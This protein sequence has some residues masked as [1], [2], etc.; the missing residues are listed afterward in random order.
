[1]FLFC[2]SFSGMQILQIGRPKQMVRDWSCHL[3]E[4][5]T[6]LQSRLRD[7]G[8]KYTS[9]E[10]TSFEDLWEC[11]TAAVVTVPKVYC[12]ADALDEMEAGHDW[13]LPKLIELG[14]RHPSTAKV[15]VT[16]RQS[17]HI[18]RIFKEPLVIP[19]SL[20]RHLIDCDIATYVSHQLS[21]QPASAFSSE[22]CQLIKSTVQGKAD[23]LFLYAR[24]MMDE[25][26]QNVENKDL[27]PLLRDLP[28]G[29]DRM[30][31]SLLTQHSLRSGVTHEVQV[32]I[33]QW[34]THASRPLR[35]LELAELVRSVPTESSLGDIQEIKNVIRSACGPLLTILPDETLQ[36]IHHSFT[37]FLV[38][39]TS[40]LPNE[41]AD[42]PLF[43]S[44][45]IHATMATTCLEYLSTCSSSSQ[46]NKVSQGKTLL[47]SD[48]TSSGCDRLFLENPLLQYVAN[49]WMIH[50]SRLNGCGADLTDSLDSFLDVSKDGFPY[51]QGIWHCSIQKR[52][53]NILKPLHVL[54]YFGLG[55]YVEVLCRRGFNLDAEDS[56]GRTPLS[57]ACERGHL[58]LVCLLLDNEASA[59][60][61]STRG[62]AP[63]HY[64]CKSELPAVVRRLLEA[65]VDPL[66]ETPGPEGRSE[67][68]R[69]R[70]GRLEN[71]ERE[72]NRRLFGV[73]ALE[74]ACTRGY[75]ECA[76][77]M[78]DFLQDKH[79]KPGALHCA[80]HE[81]RT[82]IVDLLLRRGNANPD[83]EDEFGHTPLCLA[84]KRGSPLIVGALLLAGAS[85][86]KYSSCV[87]R[88]NGSGRGASKA[89]KVKVSP[90]HAWASYGGYHRSSIEEM[91]ATGLKLIG[92]GC[93]V[94]SRD[95]E[96]RTPLFSWSKLSESSASVI[97][98]VLLEH[99]AP[100]KA[101]DNMGNTL[102]HSLQISHSELLLQT[103]IEA[104]ADINQARFIDGRTPMLCAV[105]RTRYSRS[106]DWCHYVRKF[107]LDPNAQDLE[108]KTVLHH[109]LRCDTWTVPEVE[110]WLRAGAD[111]ARQDT[112]GR[113]CLFDF[114]A[115]FYTQD[116]KISREA[117]LFSML[118]SAGLDMESR[119]HQGRNLALNAS[120]DNRLDYLMRLKAYGINVTA[121]DSQGR[122]A[123]HLLA[124]GG[125]SCTKTDANGHQ[126][127]L[128]CLNFL[129]DEGVDPN[130][131]DHLGNTMLHYCISNTGPFLKTSSFLI[132]TSLEVGADPLIRNYQGRSLLHIAA[133]LPL[134]E[135]SGYSLRDGENRLEL[136][137]PPNMNIDV[138][139]RDR[140]GVT[141]L[142]LAATR[143]AFRVARLLSSGSNVAAID[144][145]RRSALHY[146]ARARNSN[147]LGLLLATLKEQGAQSLIDQPDCNGRTPLHDAVRSGILESIQLLLDASSNPNVR[148]VKGRGCLHIASEI[149]EEH[150]LSALYDSLQRYVPVAKTNWNS[151][152]ELPEYQ[153]HPSGIDYDDP[154]ILCPNVRRTEDQDS[155]DLTDM[156]SVGRVLDV[157]RVLLHA[158]TD[159]S[160]TDND[161]KSAYNMAVENSCKDAACAILSNS[162][163]QYLIQGLAQERSES[164]LKYKLKRQSWN[165]DPA[166]RSRVIRSLVTNPADATSYLIPAISDGNESTINILLELG[167]DPLKA[168]RGELTA[169]H[170]SARCGMTSIMKLLVNKVQ[171]R[172]RLPS[173]LLHEAA[174][175]D[176]P[177]L[178]MI[179]LLV[180]FGIDINALRTAHGNKLHHQKD[181]YKVT[182]AHILAVSEHWWQP[183]ALDY[184]LEARAD[185]EVTTSAGKTALQVAIRGGFGRHIR[186]GFWR[187]AAMKTLLKHGAKVNYVDSEGETPLIEA[188]KQDATTIHTLISHGADIAFGPTSPITHAVSY[189][190][191]VEATA[192]L[193]V[194][195]FG[196]LYYPLWHLLTLKTSI[197]GWCGPEHS[198]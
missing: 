23:G 24:L 138:D 175:R 148:D 40:N 77:T 110:G 50:T 37:E 106:R 52:D 101:Q 145:S 189:P 46:Q 89:G 32:L 43:V 191:N 93:D 124:L 18:E 125:V 84:A 186:G 5:S 62:I 174:R 36:V 3:L 69:G 53:E 70:V 13:F 44:D 139:S 178:E 179:K 196:A 91:R 134:P 122:T 57:Y 72:C 129:K 188:A 73:N 34:I 90:L 59:S 107:G 165:Q 81:S 133:G 173:T 158:G 4:H 163:E 192:A 76:Q 157:V 135:D 12:V 6:L 29:V 31:T 15:M 113:H 198:F 92:A 115:C 80:V 149:Q 22:Q 1:M 180:N 21:K 181:D 126:R 16:S 2:S 117:R 54:A 160:I 47:L 104:G 190:Y 19:I 65:G 119:D 8:E 130:E 30:Y 136:L 88:R 114:Y 97:I 48:I 66:L 67:G 42:Y 123:M 11:L 64:A 185:P 171:E 162:S 79:Y 78:L 111:P 87:D 63:I 26:L 33:L 194:G 9:Q 51:W 94:N 20:S 85:I 140:N 151:E 25:V 161:G 27:E 95:S 155:P 108:G 74:L 10:H 121:K 154:A 17:P 184:L 60:I 58:E 128:R 39:S 143:S 120:N 168:R 71:H 176:N 99:G 75:I 164:A 112:K 159:P 182:A 156:E 131:Q 183:V 102:L 137:L 35:L 177:N 197:E 195:D 142:H 7:L 166:N 193:L 153:C 100:V 56:G 146:A 38:G 49:N 132:R 172:R 187:N 141:P 147:A 144:H 86:D 96:G 41:N 109:I 170:I 169:L 83:I 152:P 167:A 68:G 55:N 82:E 116:E 127:R 118:V 103:L 45:D 105:G 150:K 98:S 14:Q 61:T 28:I